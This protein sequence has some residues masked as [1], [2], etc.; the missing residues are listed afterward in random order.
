MPWYAAVCNVVGGSSTP[1]TPERIFET[2]LN[3]PAIIGRRDLSER[4]AAEGSVG[5]TE[6]RLDQDIEAF[7]AH[8]NAMA[9]REIEVL[10][11]GEVR[12]LE[13]YAL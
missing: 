7:N 6:S 2:E 3:H 13:A 9:G 5:L 11:D 4:R 1:S 8:L 10:E 12:T